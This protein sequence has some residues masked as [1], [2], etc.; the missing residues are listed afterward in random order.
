MHKN[1]GKLHVYEIPTTF[2]S[3]LEEG[4]SRQH[5]TFHNLFESFLL[6]ARDPDNLAEIENLLHRAANGW[7]DFM[8][9]YLHK[10]KIGKEMHMKINIWDYEV[11]SFILDLG[12]DVNIL[13]RNTCQNMGIPM[14]S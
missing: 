8:V 14:L 10:K 12:L 4:P 2:D 5:G 7:K 6:L 13:T 1:F 11:D 9:N 3:T